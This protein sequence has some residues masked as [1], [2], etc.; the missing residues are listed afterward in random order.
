MCA[1]IAARDDELRARLAEHVAIPTGRSHSPGVQH[2]GDVLAERLVDIGAR[3]RRISGV[4][5][6]EW[7]SLPDD[8]VVGAPV[9]DVRV[10]ERHGAE[11]SRV[12]IAGH[13]DTVHDPLGDFQRMTISDDGQTAVGP[14]VVD[15]K[16]GILVALTALEALYAMDVDLAW[17]FSFNADEET[18][19]FTSI[20]ALRELA[21]EHDI[22]IAVEPALPDGGLAIERMGSGQFRIDVHGQSAHVGRS[23][24][25]GVSAVTALARILL[26]V[27]DIA[28][29]EAGRIV[30]VGPIQGGV[31]TNAVPD[32]ASAWGNMRFRDAAAG[33]DI[34][35]RLEALATGEDAMPQIIV[36]HT[37][38]RPAKPRQPVIEAYARFVR[39]AAADLGQ[40]LPFAFTG[41]VCD[42]NI[43]QAAGL[44]TLDTLG[45]RGGNLH[46]PDE[47]IDLTSLV[48][49][50]Q[51]LAIVL[52]RIAGDT[53]GWLERCA[54]A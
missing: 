5:R 2:Y 32:R 27:A 17:T 1:W 38:N 30:S 53:P 29:P 19:S 23:F 11:T 16:G 47:W 45:V 15:M 24:T 9:H 41:G 12:L 46:R 25:E 28:D 4:A 39:K 40:K 42:G 54:P 22:G 6:S 20:D 44:P 35:R 10:F 48:E 37:C 51:V 49:R 14:G 18:G 50:S 31:V 34:I 21:A 7:L 13:L 43:L 33:E 52:S 3:E 8:P 26:D 36:H